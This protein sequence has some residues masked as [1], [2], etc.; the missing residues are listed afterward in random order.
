MIPLHVPLCWGNAPC[1]CSNFDEECG[2]GS[3]SGI[4]PA[5]GNLWRTLGEIFDKDMRILFL[6]Q[7]SVRCESLT[8]ALGE[9]KLEG[10][11]WR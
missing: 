8:M 1:T 2:W 7:F 11:T 4:M 5:G 6:M 9:C 3:Y 10:E